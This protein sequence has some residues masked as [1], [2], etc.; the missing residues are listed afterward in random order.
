[1]K[2]LSAWILGSLGSLLLLLGA[3][4]L[5]AQQTA[6]DMV[7]YNGKIVTVDDD[8]NSTRMGTI[9][10][11]ISVKNGKVERVGSNAQIRALAGPNTKLIDLKGRTVL[12]GLITTHDHPHDWDNLNPWL[13]RKTIP[14]NVVVSRFMSGTPQENLL[15]FP[16]VL[17]EAVSKAKPGQ[18][19]YIVIEYGRKYE[20]APGGNSGLGRVQLDDRFFDILDGKRIP[21]QTLDVAAP[22]NPVLLRDVF[23]STEM[24]QKAIDE[25][26]QVW[27]QYPSQ[28]RNCVSEETGI[29]TNCGLI[30][31]W[32]FPDVMMR[33]HYSQMRE[34]YRLGL[35]WWAGYGNTSVSSSCFNPMCIRVYND[36]DRAGQMAIRWSW[37]WAWRPEEIL[38][39]SYTRNVAVAIA[40]RGSDYF[41]FGGFSFVGMMAGN[42]TTL[43]PVK[44]EIAMQ[45]MNCNM[46]P[47]NRNYNALYNFIKAGGRYGYHSV[48]DKTL[49]GLMDIIEK[50]STKAGM[51]PEEIRAK[52]HSF[53]HGVMAPRADQ[54]DRIKKLGMI[55]S[56]APIEVYQAAPAIMAAYGERGAELNVPQKRVVDAGVHTA[57]EFDRPLGSTDLT[58]FHLLAMW[59]NR[60]AWDG[61]VYAP[62][63]RVSREVALKSATRGGAYYIF[64]EKELGSLEPGK[65]ADF[66]VIDR[67]YLTIP[68]DDIPNIRVL[69]TV[70]GGKVVHLVPSLA[71]EVGMQPAGAQVTLGFTPS[72][73]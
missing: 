59:I 27:A 25:V 29:G 4:F 57:F 36:L 48:G 62:D 7:L 42:C 21:K 60:K 32:A 49:D 61:K 10:Q 15:A 58:A 47:S 63:Q 5:N 67:D 56:E 64:R 35:E 30:M 17:A 52:R 65:W 20:Y 26:H 51:T 46:E 28:L 69:M 50:A 14:E 68:E 12:P 43:T 24:N 23:T 53:D 18:W 33:D 70:V 71:R 34:L 40:D 3:N 54:I 19:I 8:S 37:G 11:A 6:Q 38:M 41:W 9:G 73:W 66:M 72:K 1:M 2:S 16:K 31:R 45:P 39:E 13:I 44:P 55:A 22:D